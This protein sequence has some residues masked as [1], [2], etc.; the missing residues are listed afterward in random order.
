M[1]DSDGVELGRRHEAASDSGSA[2]PRVSVVMSVYNGEPYLRAAIDSILKQTLTELEFIIVDDGST[3]G[4]KAIIDSYVDPRIVRLRHAQ[5]LGMGHAYNRAFR[6]ARGEFIAMQDADDLSLP[7]RLLTEATCLRQDPQVGVIGTAFYEANAEGE[8]INVIA[9][10]PTD[11][12]VRWQMLFITPLC[13]GSMMFR[14]R[15]VEDNELYYEAS[16]PVEDYEFLT[17]LLKRTRVA[18][19]AAP[20]YVYRR[21]GKSTRDRLSSETTPAVLAISSRQ[22]T[23]LLPERRLTQ[24]DIEALHRCLYP[25]EITT[26]AMS[27]C[28]MMFQLF[29]A[30]EQQQGID[31]HVVHCLRRDWIKRTLAR[32]RATQWREIWISGYFSSI[33]KY[34]PMALA[35]VAPPELLK[36]IVGRVGLRRSRKN[37]RPSR[38]AL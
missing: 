11:T 24:S 6:I 18:C 28:V 19:L 8:P 35:V 32:I 1:T 36:R 27:S 34:D 17:K 7:D 2:V 23:A 31:L 20:L 21:H 38:V 15:L 5:N 30:F 12:G 25:K 14:R 16:P 10:A 3:D 33:L 37:G 22:I 4:S 26:A 29:A 9:P 13:H